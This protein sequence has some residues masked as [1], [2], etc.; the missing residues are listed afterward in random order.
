MKTVFIIL[1]ASLLGFQALSQLIFTEES[2]TFDRLFEFEV[3]DVFH[4]K[5]VFV[6]T[7]EE[8]E[9]MTN[10]TIL[11]KWYL[12]NRKVCYKR[13]NKHSS[14]YWQSWTDTTLN[15]FTKIDTV[16]YTNSYSVYEEYLY[17]Y[18]YTDSSLYH[19]RVCH[20][21][22]TGNFLPGDVDCDQAMTFVTEL[23]L[24]YHAIQCEGGGSSWS[25]MSLIYYKKGSEEWGNY[26]PVQVSEI[27]EEHTIR[28][29][30]NPVSSVL[31]ID[32]LPAV[33]QQINIIDAL[34]RVVLSSKES[35]INVEHLENG[36]YFL[37]VE[38]IDQSITQSFIKR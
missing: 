34:G 8:G 38:T 36:L 20:K 26:S 15:T 21:F 19:G 1:I 31:H 24:T 25:T 23:G 18:S 5:K 33:V 27:D 13:L 4:Y 12:D 17:N 22:R 28:L 16:C 29:Y 7:S 14:H 37:K 11:D 30:P 35:E 3:D 6:S 9:E 32:K 10:I 2:P